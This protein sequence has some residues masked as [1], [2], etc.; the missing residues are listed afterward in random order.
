MEGS[1]TTSNNINGVKIIFRNKLYICG[2]KVG[3]KISNSK[4]N[5]SE[6]FNFVKTGN[7]N[8]L[9]GGSRIQEFTSSFQVLKK[10]IVIQQL[11]KK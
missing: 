6:L 2:K 1:S 9:F 7:A 5:P 11:M 8:T 3:V 4:I 10:R